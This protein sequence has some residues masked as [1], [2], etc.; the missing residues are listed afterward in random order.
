MVLRLPV[1]VL[2]GVVSCIAA[3]RAA[4]FADLCMLPSA[5][6]PT[7]QTLAVSSLAG[8]WS[9]SRIEPQSSPLVFSMKIPR[10]L[11]LDE[12]SLGVALAVLST[13]LGLPPPV[14]DSLSVSAELPR[15]IVVDGT[16]AAAL[17][18]IRGVL[19]PSVRLSV[20][21]DPPV[22][23]AVSP[24]WVE[25]EVLAPA[26]PVFASIV[27][28]LGGRFLHR[29]DD[30][31]LRVGLS[32]S[33]VKRSARAIRAFSILP[34]YA[35]LEF[36][37]AHPSDA[38][39]LWDALVSH[40]ERHRYGSHG[41][42]LLVWPDGSPPAQ[43]LAAM[44]GT[45]HRSVRRVP[46]AA[47]FSSSVPLE[48]RPCEHRLPHRFSACPSCRVL[49]R[50][51]FDRCRQSRDCSSSRSHVPQQ[52]A[53]SGGVHCV[54]P[55]RC[56]RSFGLPLGTCPYR[57]TEVVVMR[58]FR[59]LVLLSFVHLLGACAALP[60]VEKAFFE[61]ETQVA[62]ARDERGASGSSPSGLFHLGAR[63]A[64]AWR[65]CRAGS[66]RRSPARGLS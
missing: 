32:A 10:A 8:E 66:D 16:L 41:A 62:A 61:H 53:P 23:M 28:G 39:A 58:I 37:L 6:A 20:S 13:S 1:L 45:R 56:R 7:V 3:P 12:G 33:D 29:L 60:E 43:A 47:G 22:I 18:A 42:E 19:G 51:G 17:A 49:C 14:L 40:A 57:C 30:G 2:L 54:A 46:V 21:G 35:L 4:S 64:V 34:A 36:E 27:S 55:P 48:L 26:V 15:S 52:L 11:E 25:L 50:I 44:L 65:T 63:C 38:S 31:R 9:W 24:P 5:D 59:C